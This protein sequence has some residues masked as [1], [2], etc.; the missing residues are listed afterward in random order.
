MKEAILVTGGQGRFAKI[1][2]KNNKV[3]NLYFAN[4]KE[5]NILNIKSK[6]LFCGKSKAPFKF[7]FKNLNLD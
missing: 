2:K 1:L 5:C 7:F 3:L 6:Y 4:K